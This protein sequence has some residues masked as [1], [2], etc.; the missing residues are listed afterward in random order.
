MHN[1]A[2]KPAFTNL[3]AGATALAANTNNTARVAASTSFNTSSSTSA[4]TLARWVLAAGVAG[5]VVSVNHFMEGWAESHVVA[6]WLALWA[7]AVVA[8]VVL[9]GISRW[10]AHQLMAGLD[11]WSAHV[12]HRRADARLWAMAQTD[13]RLMHELQT[14]MDRADQA[15]TPP[16][17]LTTYMSRRA[18]RLVQNQTY[19][20]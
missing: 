3:S 9:R 20:I 2:E 11:A 18:A 15:D 13:S 12:A 1:L 4:Q 5:L 8:L 6:A 17:D 14:A 16:A 10:M 19:Y 7:V